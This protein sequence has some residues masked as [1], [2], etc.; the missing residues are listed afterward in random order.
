TTTPD[1]LVAR[2]TMPSAQLLL[3]R[4]IRLAAGSPVI[5]IAESV[6]NLSALDFP[7]AWTQH[8]TLGPPFLE[9]GSTQFRAAGTRSKDTDGTEFDWPLRP[10]AQGA[11]KDLRVYTSAPK[12]SGFT[13]HLMDPH[14]EQAFFAAW[15]PRSRLLMGY[16]WRRTDFPWL[17]IWEEN[18]S[19]TTPPW[20]GQ[21]MT[22]GM[23]FGASPF[24]ETRRKMIERNGLFGVPGYRWIPAHT[25]VRVEYCAF[26][27]TAQ[28]IPEAVT[29]DGAW[30][31][32]Q[33]A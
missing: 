15:S 18:H 12:S 22:R 31:I 10:R 4:R 7:A 25:T 17:G 8:V 29:W 9:R 16:V 28:K 19:R 33:T 2:L 5:R 13:T 32:Q 21:T 23:E 14:N 11:P 30:A 6:E 20:N 24:P 26:V 3:E 1:E 27:T